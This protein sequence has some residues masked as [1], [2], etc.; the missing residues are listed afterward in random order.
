MDN[1]I[2]LKRRLDVERFVNVINRTINDVVND[3]KRTDVRWFTSFK[4]RIFTKILND[5]HEDSDYKLDEWFDF[6]DEILTERLL[7]VYQK[8]RKLS[9]KEKLIVR[10]RKLF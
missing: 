1:F 9:D 5:Y 3:P 6:L 8:I 7:K 4:N 10:K 2:N